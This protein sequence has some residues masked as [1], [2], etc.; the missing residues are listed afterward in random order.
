MQKNKKKKCP[1]SKDF[2]AQY[3]RTAQH[4]SKA[5]HFKSHKLLRH[6]TALPTAWA[7]PEVLEE[8]VLF[9]NTAEDSKA[10]GGLRCSIPIKISAWGSFKSSTKPALVLIKVYI[11]H[12]AHDF[13]NTDWAHLS[14]ILSVAAGQHF[15]P[16]NKAVFSSL[17][18]QVQTH[19]L[20]WRGLKI[21][22]ISAENKAT[23]TFSSQMHRVMRKLTL[24]SVA[25][26]QQPAHMGIQRSPVSDWWKINYLS[27]MHAHLSLETWN[28]QS[29]RTISNTKVVPNRKDLVFQDWTTETKM[30]QQLNFTIK[31]PHIQ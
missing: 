8:Q 10:F 18:C 15:L 5:Q 25:L 3:T 23:F 31:T 9:Q 20:K 11:E 1:E 14:L 4:F 17:T 13:A 22:I 26:Q 19:L 12:F 21:S 6:L 2:I 28:K 24:L 29:S 30:L 16:T 27:H 7:G